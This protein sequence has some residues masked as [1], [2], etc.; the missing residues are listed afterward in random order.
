MLLLFS[1]GA[2]R[3]E[4]SERLATLAEDPM[5]DAERDEFMRRHDTY[6]L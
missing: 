6:W 3:E 2:Q 4:Y 5:G 1:P